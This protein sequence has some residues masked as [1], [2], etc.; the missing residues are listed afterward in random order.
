VALSP[1][2]AE[3]RERGKRGGEGDRNTWFP[4]MVA[5]GILLQFV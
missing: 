1:V 5:G 3:E 4:F 2:E